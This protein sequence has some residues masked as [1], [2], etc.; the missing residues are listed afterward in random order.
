MTANASRS[1]EMAL[2]VEAVT[3]AARLAEAV[4]GA[5]EAI[6]AATKQDRSPVTVADYGVQAVVCAF[7]AEAFP[8][9]RVVA[10]ENAAELLAAGGEAMAGAV[11]EAVRRHFRPGASPDDLRRWLEH[12][13]GDG[14]AGAGRSWVLDPVDGTKGFLRGGQ[15]ALALALLEGGRPRLGLLGCPRLEAGAGG[16]RGP[17]ALFGAE[18]GAGGWQA[19]LS[20]PGDRRPLRVSAEPAGAGM[21]IAE[22]VESGH[23]DFGGQERLRTALG[24]R[25]PP[26]R[27][28][29][30]AKYGLVA[31]GDAAAYVR[32][33][34]PAT[35]DYRE[36]IWDHA[37]GAL[38]VA[39]SGGRVT[40]AR[41]RE[42]DFS[43]GATLVANAGAVA[44]N[45]LCHAAVLAAL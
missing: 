8:G 26:L 29:S 23:G 42:L 12:G 25:V 38:I 30:Q 37:A 5:G 4:S 41:G 7:L 22:S 13:R 44:T 27:M 11:L 28:D 40:D 10:E 17:G 6:R 19:P 18:A 14:A 24:C 35:P 1:G 45:G 20:A 34:N 31:R 15:Y 21:V 32:L 2:A 43:R 3:A 33:P 39:E 16:G 9:D 36:K